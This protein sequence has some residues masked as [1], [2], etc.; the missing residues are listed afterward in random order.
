MDNWEFKSF[1]D[2]NNP[3]Q[4]SVNLDEIRYYESFS[5]SKKKQEREFIERKFRSSKAYCQRREIEK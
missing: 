2:T 4:T 5:Y 3:N 1:V